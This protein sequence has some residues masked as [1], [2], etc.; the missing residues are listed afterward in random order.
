MRQGSPQLL[1]KIGWCDVRDDSEQWLTS[2]RMVYAD[3]MRVLV[4]AER[5]GGSLG[6]L[7]EPGGRSFLYSVFLY[8]ASYRVTPVAAAALGQGAFH[9]AADGAGGEGSLFA[10]TYV[11]RGFGRRPGPRAEDGAGG[12]ARRWAVVSPALS[13]ARQVVRPYAIDP[14]SRRP[15]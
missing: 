6:S 1:T 2:R 14:G 12:R 5:S 4:G 3:G 8:I 15:L 10:V 9:G 7:P 13:P 11:M